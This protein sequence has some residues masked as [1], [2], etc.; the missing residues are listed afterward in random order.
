MQYLGIIPHFTNKNAKMT[1]PRQ[2]CQAQPK[3][4]LALVL[5]SPTNPPWLV[6]TSETWELKFASLPKQTKPCYTKKSDTQPSQAR[7][8]HINQANPKPKLDMRLAHLSPSL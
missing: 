2:Y 6:A 8:N 1:I 3:L 7:P 4:G 5:I